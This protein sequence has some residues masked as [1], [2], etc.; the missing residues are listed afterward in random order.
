MWLD[1]ARDDD[2]VGV[3]NYE[4]AVYDARGPV[5][6]Q[7][8]VALNQL[9]SSDI[10]PL[11]LA[12]AVRYAHQAAGVPVLVTEHGLGHAD[13]SLRAAFIGPALAGLLDAV[14]DGVPV[15]GYLHWSLLDNF[16]WVFG[17]DVRFGLH[18]VDRATFARIPKPSAAV[19]AAIARANGGSL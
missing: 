8:G 1:L 19:Y 2:F 9:G 4:R 16:E 13:D 18:E 6:P 12:G 11:S 17:F 10:Y 3:Q 7:P 5:P 15:L 14:Q